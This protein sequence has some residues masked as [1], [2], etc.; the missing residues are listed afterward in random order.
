MNMCHG[1]WRETLGLLILGTSVPMAV[2]ECIPSSPSQEPAVA[3]THRSGTASAPRV[4]LRVDFEHDPIGLYDNG[5]LATDFANVVGRAEGLA[6][7]RVSIVETDHGKSLRVRYPQGS[8]GPSE[9]GAQFMVK[10]APARDEVFCSYR[11]R[12]AADF[13]FVRGGKLPGLVGGSHPT[14]GRPRN[15][16]WSARMMW[17]K[18]GAAVQYLYFPQQ[19]TTYGVD[20]PYVN[21]GSELRFRPGTWHLVEHHIVMNTPGRSDGILQAWLDGKLALDV[22]DRVWRLDDGVHIDAFYFSTFFGGNDPSWGA[23]R[24]ETIDFDDFVLTPGQLEPSR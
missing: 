8:V 15:D 23:S 9:G 13:G 4:L 22:H 14:G 2:P 5:K 17:R 6:E 1:S 24:D 20:L 19:T 7:G 10:I 16:G 18:G 21:G 3:V 11:V 12:F